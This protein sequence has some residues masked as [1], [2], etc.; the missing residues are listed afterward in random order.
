V[1][2]IWPLV[3]VAL[4]LWVVL[5]GL[6]WRRNAVGEGPAW[7]WALVVGAVVAGVACLAVPALTSSSLRELSYWVDWLSLA[8]IAAA[9]GAVAFAF[10]WPLVRLWRA[11][12]SH[13]T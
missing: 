11:V 5:V 6:A 4:L 1:L 7:T 2:G 8:G 3:A 10:A 13:A 12:G 9:A